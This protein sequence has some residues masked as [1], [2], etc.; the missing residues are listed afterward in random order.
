M[1]TAKSTTAKKPAVTKPATKPATKKT[2]AAVTTK[3]AAKKPA[4]V[5]KTAAATAK[6]AA[7]VAVKKAAAATKTAPA[8]VSSTPTPEQRYRMVQDAAYFIAEKNGFKA[9]SM[10]YW[11]AAEIEI[12]AALSGKGKK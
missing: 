7:P 4:T 10:D 8:K 2:T 5:K 12:E 3:V 6:P 11:I 9:G 1:A